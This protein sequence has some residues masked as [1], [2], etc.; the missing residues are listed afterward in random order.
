MAD[1]DASELVDIGYTAEVTH[2]RTETAIQACRKAASSGHADAAPKA[3]FN[4]GVLLAEQGD[5]DGREGRL[6]A[7]HRLRARRWAPTAAVNLGVLLRSRVMWTGARAAY[8][9]AIDS[10]HADGRRGRGRPGDSAG[11]AG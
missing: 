11:G 3:A 7:G 8:Q 9:Q 2:H 5:A 1:A 6:P 4:L 10:G